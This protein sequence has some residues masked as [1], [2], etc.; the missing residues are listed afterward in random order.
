MRIA[1]FE[2][3][4][5][6]GIAASDGEA[7]HGLLANQA[8]FP[9]TIKRVLQ[10]GYDLDLVGMKLLEAPAVNLEGKRFLPPVFDPGKVICVGLNYADHAAETGLPSASFPTFFGRFAS[11][12]T[13]HERPIIKPAN[14]D[15]LDFEGELAVVIG[16]QG[17]NVQLSDA[18]GYVAGYSVFND[19]SVRDVQF[20]STQ[21]MLGKNCDSTGAFG[22]W[23]VT[24]SSLSPGAKGLRLRTLL[25]GEVMQESSTDL[26]IH[27]VADLIAMA[28]E[29]MTLH[30]GD[31][32]VTG[33]PCGVG[34]SRTPPVY[35]RPGDVCEIEIEGVGRLRNLIE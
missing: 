27:G 17:R 2:A 8:G 4:G 15:Q 16:R 24:P 11:S 10:E 6:V 12:L 5:Q 1:M 29:V 34:Y 23:V 7:F 3:D 30:P 33:T 25:N 26:M 22:P 28:S 35:M 19:A 20:R 21:W 32:I 31:I 18:L 14:S 9:G 13:A